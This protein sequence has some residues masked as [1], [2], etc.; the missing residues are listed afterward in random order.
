MIAR[1]HHY[2][3]QCYLRGFTKN[4]AKKSQLICIDI[5]EKRT[6]KTTPQN[7]GSSKDFNKITID[8]YDP[9][10]L[11]Y[12]IS[13]FESEAA[14]AMRE[15]ALCPIF[16]GKNKNIILYMMALFTLRSPHKR[17]QFDK[18]RS[19]ILERML[20]I[21]LSSKEQYENQINKI[22]ERETFYTKKTSYEDVKNLHENKGYTLSFQ[23]ESYIQMEFVGIDAILP[24]LHN[25]NWLLLKST[26]ESGPFITTDNP[27][28]LIWANPESIPPFYRSAPGF[29]LKGTQVYFPLSKSLALI[30]E[31]NEKSGAT[32]NAT[33][34][35]VAFFN[36]Q[37]I[38]HAKKQ[39][40]TPDI[41]FFYLNNKE[42]ISEGSRLLHDI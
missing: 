40:Y 19:K 12:L 42:T 3:S 25:R 24:C 31:F 6:F 41:D 1:R 37:A 27:V 11:E 10:T 29:G 2:L 23:N 34:Q 30:G 15:L 5:K 33:K 13:E 26:L 28:S 17:A 36:R 39:L 16:E 35:L 22:K 8:D 21:T 9:N 38:A 32:V 18:F 14:V 4:E 20:D 7:V